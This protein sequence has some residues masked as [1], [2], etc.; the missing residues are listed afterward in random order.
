MRRR[1]V[2]KGDGTGGKPEERRSTTPATDDADVRADDT[3]KIISTT[4]IWV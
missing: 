2:D 1:E 3:V 4:I